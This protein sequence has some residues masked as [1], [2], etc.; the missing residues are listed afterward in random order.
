MVEGF[1]TITEEFLDSLF[2]YEA[3]LDREVWEK[4]VADKAN[5]VFNPKLVRAKVLDQLK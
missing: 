5:W 4:A 3:K 1:E 2:G